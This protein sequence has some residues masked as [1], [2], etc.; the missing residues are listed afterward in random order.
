MRQQSYHVQSKTTLTQ[1]GL[2]VNIRLFIARREL[3]R[4]KVC[5]MKA[6]GRKK[7]ID[8]QP[9]MLYRRADILGPMCYCLG[10]MSLLK[11]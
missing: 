2:N 9:S 11:E 5:S 7:K 6:L 8:E 3:H 1:D 10:T 4:R